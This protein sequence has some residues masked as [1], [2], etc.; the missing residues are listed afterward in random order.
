[1]RWGLAC[2]GLLWVS[3]AGAAEPLKEAAAGQIQLDIEPLEYTIRKRLEKEAEQS[4]QH[5]DSIENVRK[6]RELVDL[7]TSLPFPVVMWE[8]Q[9]VL[10]GPLT[11]A[12]QGT[13]G[14][15]KNGDLDAK[16]LHEEMSQLSGRLK[17]LSA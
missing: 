12:L 9:N 7:V 10:F 3:A 6:L 5:L 11:Q 13:N 4:V 2:C 15:G 17:I 14:F 8:A 1:M 16:A